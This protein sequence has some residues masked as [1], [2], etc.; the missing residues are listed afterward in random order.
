[1]EKSAVA[2]PLEAGFSDTWKGIISLALEETSE[3]CS[4]PETHWHLT[5]WVMKVTSSPSHQALTGGTEEAVDSWGKSAL[6]EHLA[7][8]A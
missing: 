2:W 7:S 6:A 3:L 4:S 8:R 5:S 1:M